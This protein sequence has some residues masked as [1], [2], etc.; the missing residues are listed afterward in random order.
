MNFVPQLLIL[1][2]DSLILFCFVC[3]F[4]T[5]IYF[6]TSKMTNYCGKY[7]SSTHSIT[8]LYKHHWPSLWK[9]QEGE[10]LGRHHVR[11]SG[12]WR[13]VCCAGFSTMSRTYRILPRI[14]LSAVHGQSWYCLCRIRGKGRRIACVMED[15]SILIETQNLWY[16]I[17]LKWFMQII[18]FKID[19]M[20]TLL[21]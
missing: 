9:L 19:F 11:S 7:K 2:G 4:L 6:V 5:L 17:N 1:T 13:G 20:Q 18:W 21:Q 10:C 15:D 14:I 8:F 3:I 12:A 16:L